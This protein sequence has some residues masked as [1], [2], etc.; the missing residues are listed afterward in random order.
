MMG[1]YEE[2]GDK[3]RDEGMG[4]DADEDAERPLPP[5]LLV[6]GMHRRGEIRRGREA[7]SG[8]EVHSGADGRRIDGER[9]LTII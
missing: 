2:C 9:P 4:D 5:V 1:E 6:A 8:A 3:R 7:L